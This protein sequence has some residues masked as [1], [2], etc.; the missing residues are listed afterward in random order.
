MVRSLSVGLVDRPDAKPIIIVKAQKDAFRAS[1]E[2]ATAITELR[3][4][5]PS[6]QSE[7]DVVV[8]VGEPA[9]TPRLYGASADRGR[10]AHC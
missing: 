3:T 7:L 10:D 5:L 2:A 6:E 8:M 1:W 9:E 4:R